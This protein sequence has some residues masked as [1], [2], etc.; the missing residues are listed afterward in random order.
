M[1]R[2]LSFLMCL[3]ILLQSMSIVYASGQVNFS[4]LPSTHW[5]YQAVNDMVSR[6]VLNG[7]EDGTFRPNDYVTKE[8]FAKVLVLSFNLP[9]LDSETP[10]F[11][12]VTKANW[13]YKYVESAKDFI[14]GYSENE[15][16]IYNPS[17]PA[18]REEMAYAIVK[19]KGLVMKLIEQSGS[20]DVTVLEKY[21]DKNDISQR[22]EMYVAVAIDNKIMEGDGTNFNPKKPLT[23]AEACMLIYKAIGG[24]VEETISNNEEANASK[25]FAIGDKVDYGNNLF[26]YKG[27]YIDDYNPEYGS[28]IVWTNSITNITSTT[29]MVNIHIKFYDI[30]KKCIGD[31]QNE[32]DL[33]VDETSPFAVPP[34]GRKNPSFTI[35]NSH[36]NEGKTLND[37]RYFSIENIIDN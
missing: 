35:R 25:L 4:D 12:D 6:G 29:Q 14:K 22:L 28:R 2:A 32:S 36:L 11:S 24:V 17:S 15:K 37:V 20:I 26:E 27:V 31:Y 16:V 30:D 34:Q 8:Q 23:R 1:K 10:A 21:S 3:T 18:I 33:T 5:A 13:S 7:F 19:V 9:L